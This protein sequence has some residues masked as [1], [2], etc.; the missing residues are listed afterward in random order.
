MIEFK[1]QRR[2]DVKTETD[3]S[4]YEKMIPS[5]KNY[6]KISEAVFAR[7]TTISGDFHSAVQVFKEYAGKA[8]G[9]LF[10]EG[11]DFTV[12]LDKSLEEGEYAIVSTEEKVTVTAGGREGAGYALATLLQL[13]ENR[14]GK[15]ALGCFDIS[16]KADNGYRGL[17]IDCAR[18]AH[19][20]PLLKKYVDLCFFYKIKYL[21]LHFTDDQAYTLPSRFLPRLT[22]E[23]NHYTE[24]EIAELVQYA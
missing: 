17:M 13:I 21:H 12:C 19:P 14:N 3:M 6:N 9:L 2:T 7:N 16:D 20:L 24:A 8:H 5:P 4:C 18:N 23:H 1:K 11:D 22:S 15:A 10:T